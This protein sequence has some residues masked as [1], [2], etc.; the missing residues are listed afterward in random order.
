MCKCVYI[1]N[2]TFQIKKYKILNY[3]YMHIIN[4][5]E[6]NQLGDTDYLQSNN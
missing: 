3:F 2:L 1:F 6:N 4:K 5:I